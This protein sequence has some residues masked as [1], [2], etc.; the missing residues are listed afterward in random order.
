MGPASDAE[1][2]T[3]PADAQD[4][5]APAPA[6]ASKSAP[7]SVA[8]PGRT[9]AP[10]SA[11]SADAPAKD[12]ASSANATNVANA[13]FPARGDEGANEAM[14]PRTGASAAAAALPGAAAFV[15]GE[16]QK[17]SATAIGQPAAMPGA[18]SPAGSIGGALFA[19]VLVVGLILALAWLA[20]RMPGLGGALGGARGTAALRI[21]GSLALGPRERVVV[22]A[23][24]DTQLLLGVGAGGTRTLH[25][26]DAPLPEQGA[27]QKTAPAFAQLLAQQFGK[28]A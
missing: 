20:R 10:A 26:L 16:K 24:G 17:S 25:T 9:V 15:A 4:G 2:L 18:S 11:H 13:A 22:V 27:G 8:A 7:T 6:G 14:Q 3:A 1:G 19:L 28:K 12:G 21:V 23:V 5:G